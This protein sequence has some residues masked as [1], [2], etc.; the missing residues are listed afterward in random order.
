MELT[1]AVVPE[2]TSHC[3][4]RSDTPQ[5]SRQLGTVNSLDIGR[6]FIDSQHSRRSLDCISSVAASTTP[7]PG[8][9]SSHVA[10]N[11]QIVCP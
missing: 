5:V 10:M 7:R 2:K 4:S 6:S 9:V 11:D 3:K 8:L 1:S